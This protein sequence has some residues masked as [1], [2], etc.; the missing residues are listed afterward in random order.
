MLL[1]IGVVWEGFFQS[2]FTGEAKDCETKKKWLH[3]ASSSFFSAYKMS[4]RYNASIYAKRVNPKPVEALPSGFY[5]WSSCTTMVNK[6]AKWQTPSIGASSLARQD[7]AHDADARYLIRKKIRPYT[8]H[9]RIV[10]NIYVH[11]IGEPRSKDPNENCMQAK[12]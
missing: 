11:I 2:D 3:P 6:R 5:A 9:Q 1:D 4:S 7:G 10:L 12:S 8:L